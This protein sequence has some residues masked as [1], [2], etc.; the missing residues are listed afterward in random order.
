MCGSEIKTFY[1]KARDITVEEKNKAH[2]SKKNQWRNVHLNQQGWASVRQVNYILNI[3][4]E[5]CIKSKGLLQDL[6]DLS[7]NIY[8]SDMIWKCKLLW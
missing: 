1:S 2:I 8:G 5:R 4:I 7:A 3:Y 6:L